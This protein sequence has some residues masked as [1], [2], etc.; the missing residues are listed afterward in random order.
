MRSLMISPTMRMADRFSNALM[1]WNPGACKPMRRSMEVSPTPA[2]TL[3]GVCQHGSA[4]NLPAHLFDEVIAGQRQDLEPTPFET[5]EPLYEYCY[6][7]AGVVGLAS[8]HV[9][10]FDGCEKPPSNWRS[11]AAWRFNS[12]TFCAISAKM[13]AVAGCI[14]RRMN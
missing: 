2:T 10:G 6:R 13:P 7:V 3:A 9:W 5:F 1:I 4:H 11:N 12:P 14:C 8:I